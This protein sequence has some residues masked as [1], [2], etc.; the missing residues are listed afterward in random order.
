MGNHLHA[1]LRNL[2]CNYPCLG[3]VSMVQMFLCT[4]PFSSSSRHSNASPSD[5]LSIPFLYSYYDY[6]SLT[7]L[8][9]ILQARHVFQVWGQHFDGRSQILA[10]SVHC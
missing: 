1:S 3:F 6:F 4:F 8:R 2:R 9:F 7:V 10:V 5:L